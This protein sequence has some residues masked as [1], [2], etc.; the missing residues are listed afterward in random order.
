[1][2]RFRYVAL[3]SKKPQRAVPRHHGLSFREPETRG[4]LRPVGRAGF[5]V[6]GI[7]SGGISP[8]A[9][10]TLISRFNCPRFFSNFFHAAGRKSQLFLN[11]V[12]PQF[13]LLADS[14]REGEL[15]I[16]HGNF[17]WFSGL[18]NDLGDGK[19]MRFAVIIFGL[20]GEDDLDIMFVEQL[21][22]EGATFTGGQS[23]ARFGMIS[24]GN[25]AEVAVGWI[26]RHHHSRRLLRRGRFMATGWEQSGQKN[27]DRRSCLCN[28]HVAKLAGIRP[29]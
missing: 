29:I 17:Q 9:G 2:L 5:R 7:H 14:R 3:L 27:H 11:Q 28:P 6:D 10:I 26:G 20:K 16:A 15:Q 12:L 19:I 25:F 22:G 18:A 4:A 21:G 23:Q 8:A 24:Q 13:L 1:M